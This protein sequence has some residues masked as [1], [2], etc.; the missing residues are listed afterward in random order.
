M[1][2]NDRVQLNLNESVAFCVCPAVEIQCSE[3]EFCLAHLAN[4]I[5]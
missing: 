1:M 4:G 3:A 5:S 2:Q